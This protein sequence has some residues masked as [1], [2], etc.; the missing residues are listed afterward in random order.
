MNE[1]ASPQTNRKRTKKKAR[2]ANI[3]LETTKRIV[4]FSIATI[5]LGSAQC[6]F[7]PMLDICKRTP[8]LILGLIIA[9]ALCDNGKSAMIVSIG[10]GFFVDAIGGAPLSFSPIIYFALATVIGIASEKMLK[11]FPSYL[12]LLLP[13][14]LYRAVCTTGLALINKTATLSGEF[15]LNTVLIEAVSTLILCLPIYFIINIA[16]KPLRAHKKFSF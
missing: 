7:F 16:T 3:K 10:A 9:V 6:S 8:D 1:K 14:L 13:S 12:L 4:I 2:G 5:I 15:F 11:S